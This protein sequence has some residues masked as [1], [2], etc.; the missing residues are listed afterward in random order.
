VHAV[1]LFSPDATIL[2]S[3]G[4]DGAIMLWRLDV[5]APKLIGRIQS[6]NTDYHDAPREMAFSQDGHMLAASD[7]NYV[8]LFDLT[9]P[10]VETSDYSH[11]LKETVTCVSFDRGDVLH[12]A[13][14]SKTL[15]EWTLKRRS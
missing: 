15:Y 14:T 6:R 9:K 2:A 8:K 3:S 13:D 7:G 1:L 5:G 12:I 11:K 4:A 10:R